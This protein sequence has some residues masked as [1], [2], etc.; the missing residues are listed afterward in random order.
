MRIIHEGRGGYIEIS[1]RRYAI[2]HVG[3]GRF[4]IHFP[5]GN[6]HAGRAADLELLARLVS[7]EPTKWSLEERPRREPAAT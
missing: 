3:D 4:A 7:D 1:G 6:R 5:S 2:E